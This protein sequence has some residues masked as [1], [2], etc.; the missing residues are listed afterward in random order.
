MDQEAVLGSVLAWATGDP[1]VRLVV[2]TGSYARGEADELSD[3][4]VELYVD[5]PSELLANRSW[6]ERFGDVVVTEELE[7]PGWHPT[8]LVYYIDGKIDF[9][10]ASASVVSS[11]TYDAPFR[12][13]LDKDGVTP[14]LRTIDPAPPTEEE[15]DRCINWFYAAAIM[16]AKNLS[17]DDPWPAKTRDHDL[18][19]E[20]LRMI[21]WA[22]GSRHGWDAPVGNGGKRI[23]HW[24]DDDIS[25]DVASCWA[26]FS[27]DTSAEALVRSTRLFDRLAIEVA[28][29]LGVDATL[30]ERASR[31]VDRLLSSVA[32]P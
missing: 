26:G 7:N 27:V 16:C 18:K 19:S 31:E 14:K 17:R 30:V 29:G 15:F 32:R 3:L 20:L 6:F 1:N 5:E 23:L 2:V 25:R 10:I 24:T 4:D 21:E 28:R 12:V 22:H 13:V 9:M 11:V 8:R